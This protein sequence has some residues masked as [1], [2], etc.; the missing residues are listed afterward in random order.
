ME[1]IHEGVRL[2]TACEVN[3]RWNKRMTDLEATIANKLADERAAV[4]RWLRGG[5]GY[6]DRESKL[7][8]YA[9]ANGIERGEHR[10]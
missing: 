10:R 2:C 3:E 7:A 8:I 1:Q 6:R 9:A 4:V 5:L